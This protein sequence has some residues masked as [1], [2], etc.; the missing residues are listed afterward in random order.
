MRAETTFNVM[1]SQAHLL[2]LDGSGI[3]HLAYGERRLRE[4]ESRWSRFRS[5]SDI[6]RLNAAAGRAITVGRDT[7]TLLTRSIRAWRLT[8]G[9]F[10]PTVGQ[11]MHAYGYDRDFSLLGDRSEP[12]GSRPAPGCAGIEL[13][14]DTGR[15]RMP[16]AVR[17]DAGGIGKGLAADLVAGELLR[18]GAGGVVVNVGGDLRV[19]GEPPDAAGWV[20]GVDDPRRPGADLLRV[21]LPAGAI[22]TSST[23]RRRWRQGATDCHH[24]M[25]PHTGR[26]AQGPSV[27][28][29]VVAAEAWWAEVMAKALLLAERPGEHPLAAGVEF[30]VLC[31]DGEVVTSPA[32]TGLVAA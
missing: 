8:E 19:A 7:M 15:V 18:R 29:S 10:D 17:F 11:S 21:A 16:A 26:P 23:L 3:D 27:A 22:A 1:G 13:D 24:L 28:V 9:A 6:G 12:A 20:V 32:L 14:H 5:D 31:A 2:V 4:L 25:D 30:V